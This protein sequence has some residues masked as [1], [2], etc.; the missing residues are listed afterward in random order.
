MLA[1]EN[2]IK[3]KAVNFMKKIFTYPIVIKRGCTTDARR[4]LDE[5]FGKSFAVVCDENTEYLAK[6]SF[7]YSKKVLF[8]AGSHATEENADILINE[9][10]SGKFQCLV[11]CG[12]GSVHDITRYAC[13]S[14]KIPF[15]S[16]PTAPSVDGFVSNVAAMTFKG[17][18]ITF[19]STPPAALFADANVYETAPSALTASGVGD[20][21]GKYVSLFDWEFTALL[22]DETVEDDIYKLE[23]DA[24]ESVMNSD[25]GSPDYIE[26]VMQCLVKSGIAIQMKGSSRPA[27]GAEHHLSHLW[28]MNCISDET[29]ALH[30]EKVGVSTLLV[31]DRYKRSKALRFRPKPLDKE[32]LLPI[33]GKLSDGIIE[34]N[35][36]D[37]LAL[38]S[39]EKLDRCSDSI[40][41]LIDALPSPD[42]I[43]KYLLSV[44][45]KTTLGELGLP[46]NA[47]FA[48]KSLDYA[49]YVRSRLT[50]LKVI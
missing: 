19:P 23:R 44:G 37:T 36:P 47:E 25:I 3:M 46:D 39:Q 30:G 32:Y 17:R 21:V 49:P 20:I 28:E 34:E 2:I 9:I 42:T 33:F 6:D 40:I 22:T 38:I 27:S 10:R 8:P 5:N 11:A 13:H 12:S 26:H 15:V 7:P 29:D 41:K 50:M 35:T 14:E 43:R 48:E 18:K 24:L 1:T 4:Y 16:F 31:L 45:A